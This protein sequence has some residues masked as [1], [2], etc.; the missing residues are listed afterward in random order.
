VMAAEKHATD[1]NEKRRFPKEDY[2]TI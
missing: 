1:K 2:P